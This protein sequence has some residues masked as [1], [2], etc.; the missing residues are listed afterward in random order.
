[1]II[2]VSDLHFFERRADGITIWWVSLDDELLS[3]TTA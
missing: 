3:T 2:V 1:M